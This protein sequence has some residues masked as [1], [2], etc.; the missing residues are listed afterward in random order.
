VSR[1][2][3]FLGINQ[4]GQVSVIRTNGNR[5]GH[6]V[7]RGG[8][9]GPN[10]DSVTMAVVE[11]ELARN[12]LAANTMV[13]CSHANSNKDHNLQ[14]LVMLDC[15][16]QILEGNQSIIG[17]MIESNINAG[18]QAIPADLTQLKYGVSVTDAC[19][20]WPTTE[21]LL[22]DTRTKLKDVLPKRVPKTADIRKI[23]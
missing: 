23:G 8:A 11:K 22:R 16:H 15:A 9:K 17:V 18:N 10:Y 20:D 12:R 19:I 6:I 13:D 7:L 1:P 21:K 2:H 5:Y 3:S 14:P 4:R